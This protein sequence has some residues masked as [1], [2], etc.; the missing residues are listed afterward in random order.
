VTI[1][2]CLISPTRQAMQQG[3]TAKGARTRRLALL[4]APASDCTGSTAPMD[5]NFPARTGSVCTGSAAPRVPVS[6]STQPVRRVPRCHV[7]TRELRGIFAP[8]PHGAPPGW[9]D[10]LYVWVEQARTETAHGGSRFDC[11]RDRPYPVSAPPSHISL[12]RVARSGSSRLHGHSSASG[13]NSVANEVDCPARREEKFEKRG[14]LAS[15]G[16]AERRAS[17]NRWLPEAGPRAVTIPHPVDEDL[18]FTHFLNRNAPDD[19]RGRVRINTRAVT[20]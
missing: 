16:M 3:P 18:G 6:R 1:R 4:L 20:G 12:T 7:A 17:C 19:Y 15:T 10:V 5:V 11:N 13:A 14:I 9:T 2:N 8:R